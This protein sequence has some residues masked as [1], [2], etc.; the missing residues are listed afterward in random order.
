MK[1]GSG[2]IPIKPV[3]NR[4]WN[5]PARQPVWNRYETQS[6]NDLCWKQVWNRVWNRAPK[7]SVRSRSETRYETTKL[8]P[9]HETS[10]WSLKSALVWNQLWNRYE[11]GMKPKGGANLNSLRHLPLCTKPPLDHFFQFNY[12]TDYETAMKPAWNRKETPA[13]YVSRIEDMH[14]SM[15]WGIVS[16]LSVE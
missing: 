4:V 8:K 2:F 7:W 13:L 10:T 1:P 11:T 5:R 16:H 3:W 14:I 6:Q 15:V 9:R 12:E